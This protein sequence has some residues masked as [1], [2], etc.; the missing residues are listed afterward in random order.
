MDTI[1]NTY[2]IGEKVTLDEKIINDTKSSRNG[3]QCCCTEAGNLSR[4]AFFCLFRWEINATNLTKRV[5]VA[6]VYQVLNSVIPKSGS[7]SHGTFGSAFLL[8]YC[9]LAISL[10]DHTSKCKSFFGFSEVPHQKS[11]FR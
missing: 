2:L 6:V 8:D 7:Y 10:S 5:V 4:A 3:A 11:V 1:R 9:K